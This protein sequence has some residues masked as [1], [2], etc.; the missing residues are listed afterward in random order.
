MQFGSS[1]NWNTVT[2]NYP[3]L[4][5]QIYWEMGTGNGWIGYTYGKDYGYMEFL[6]FY[7]NP[8]KQ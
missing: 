6:E 2:N 7:K 8:L 1:D 3:N 4:E 5:Q